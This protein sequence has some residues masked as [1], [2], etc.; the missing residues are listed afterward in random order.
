MEVPLDFFSY[1]MSRLCCMATT[2]PTDDLPLYFS[3]KKRSILMGLR[4]YQHEDRSL[5]SPTENSPIY[6]T[7]TK[8]HTMLN[9]SI[10]RRILNL[11]KAQTEIIYFNPCNVYLQRP[12]LD[13]M[14]VLMTV[15]KTNL[16]LLPCKMMGSGNHPLRDFSRELLINT[17]IRS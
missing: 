10:S 13:S 12:I 7:S 9:C 17:Q 11:I 4:D 16:F 3:K 8:F 15:K 2:F 14:Y 1:L 6:E 5:C